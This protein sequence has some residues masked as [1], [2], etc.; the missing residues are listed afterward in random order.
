[1]SKETMV[2]KLFSAAEKG[3]FEEINRLVIQEGID[4][5]TKFDGETVADIAY[6]CGHKDVARSLVISGVKSTY[7]VGL[8]CYAAKTGDRDLF[9]ICSKF[10]YLKGVIDSEDQTPVELAYYNGHKEFAME[11]LEKHYK[12]PT[13]YSILSKISNKDPNVIEGLFSAVNLG[14]VNKIEE[15]VNV[16]NVDLK[17]KDK[18]GK[19]IVE[20]AYENKKIDRLKSLM[21]KN[22]YVKNCINEMTHIAIG[23]GNLDLLR[24]LVNELNVDTKS[25]RMVYIAIREKK[26]DVVKLLV[27]E[28]NVDI[29]AENNAILC[30]AIEY[31]PVCDIDKLN[32]DKKEYTKMGKETAGYTK[33]VEFL[34]EAG[35]NPTEGMYRSD[36]PIFRAFSCIR[37]ERQRYMVKLLLEKARVKTNLNVKDNTG[38]T[39]LL[40]AIKYQDVQTVQYLLLKAKVDPDIDNYGKTPL[41]RAIILNNIAIVKELLMAKANPNTNFH[42]TPL[43]QAIR[44]IRRNSLEIVKL[45]VKNGANPNMT[46]DTG[47]TPL[48]EAV[49]MDSEEVIEYLLPC[50]ERRSDSDLYMYESNLKTTLKNYPEVIEFFIEK[51]IEIKQIDDYI[52]KNPDIF[53]TFVQ[54]YVKN[55][56]SILEFLLQNGAEVNLIEPEYECTGLHDAAGKGN[57]GAVK[58][59]IKYG[60]NI[61]LRNEGGFTPLDLAKKNEHKGVVTFLEQLN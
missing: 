28:L 50:L 36:V 13:K 52:S 16:Q 45:L 61:N 8:L 47:H 11:I 35:A 40:C 10:V 34:L 53:N 57:L 19:T 55:Y 5:N 60:A 9:R 4:I 33:I 37:I 38:D 25:N 46:S 2:A 3:D 56:L 22:E 41:M 21:D 23:E 20:R 15:L 44:G 7:Y 17:A 51:G 42:Y 59:L 24:L 58:L 54:G 39:I 49:L 32:K 26:L 30:E 43:V 29:R 1:M 27:N 12:S 31:M 48:M 18:S 14:D 6:Q